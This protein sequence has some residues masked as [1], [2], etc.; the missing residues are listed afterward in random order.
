LQ[1]GCFVACLAKDEGGLQKAVNVLIKQM[2]LLFFLRRAENLLLLFPLLWWLVAKWMH[3]PQLIDIHLHDTYIVAEASWL[4][5]ML[6]IA[7]LLPY[8]LHL[9][10]RWLRLRQALW[11]AGHVWLTVAAMALLLYAPLA[12]ADMTRRYLIADTSYRIFFVPLLLLVLLQLA[13]FIY[14]VIRLVQRRK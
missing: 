13:F 14:T 6:C 3:L 12:G 9:L 7:M 2:K 5:L 11:C 8:S 1:G 4:A 10:L